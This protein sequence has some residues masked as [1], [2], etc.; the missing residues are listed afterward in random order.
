MKAITSATQAIRFSS[1]T[2]PDCAVVLRGTS[3]RR[4]PLRW[5]ETLR[6]G[7]T[8][9]VGS[10]ERS[11]AGSTGA[12]RTGS[13]TALW[14]GVTAGAETAVPICAAVSPLVPLSAWRI[15]I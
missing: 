3:C 7:R 14:A 2:V 4:L 9:A 8:F 10:I 12:G 6:F 15:G 5:T 1:L 11:K 13:A